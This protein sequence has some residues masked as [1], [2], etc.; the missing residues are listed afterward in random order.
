LEEIAEIVDRE[1]LAHASSAYAYGSAQVEAVYKR[2]DVMH[3]LIFVLL[4]LALSAGSAAGT[5]P[6]KLRNGQI[7][8]WSDRAFEGRA[9]VFVMNP[10]GTDQRRLT[11]LFSAK[12]GDFSPDG[13]KLVFDGRGRE[14]LDDFDIYVMNSDGSA[15]KQLTRGPERDTQASWSPSG[16]LVT[17]V[18][19]KNN[20]SSPSIWMVGADGSNAH[21]VTAGGS[22]V[23]SPDG[24]RLAVGGFGLKIVNT[25]EKRAKTIV[26]GET[27][28]AA[29]SRDG[30]R[31]L[32]TGYRG[33]NPDVYVVRTDGTGLRRLTRRAGED[34][35][36]DFS[37]D[38]RKILFSSDRIGYKQVYVMNLDGSGV[39][40]LSRSQ[41]SDWA[42]SWQPVLG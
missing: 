6:L 41:S 28:V 40:N 2:G 25:E 12:R 13:Q 38:G 19:V 22:A 35:A 29:W 21:R 42:T 34:Y 33:A 5:A 16:R 31:I 3:R 26:R 17:Y 27:E 30:R 8:F 1:V 24:K 32:F 10:D 20:S 15:V 36:A 9:Q 39:R 23:W 11:E 18:R 7:S 37:P 4:A 14:T